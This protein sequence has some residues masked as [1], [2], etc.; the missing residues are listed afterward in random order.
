LVSKFA[1]D[2]GFSLADVSEVYGIFSVTMDGE[3]SISI[4]DM[5][6]CLQEKCI[7]GTSIEYQ[8][9]GEHR[10]SETHRLLIQVLDVPSCSV[11]VKISEIILNVTEIEGLPGW[12]L[13]DPFNLDGQGNEKISIACVDGQSIITGTLFLLWEEPQLYP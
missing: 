5:K 1:N 3:S 6:E 9:T 4:V 11:Q 2:S 7:T 8:K 12:Y 13:S 10:F